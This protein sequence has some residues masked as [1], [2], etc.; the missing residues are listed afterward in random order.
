MGKVFYYR[1]GCGFKT[2]GIFYGFIYITNN[3][4]FLLLPLNR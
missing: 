4:F 3:I 1:L 2:L